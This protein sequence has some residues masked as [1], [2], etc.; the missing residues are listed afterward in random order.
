MAE[1][2]RGDDNGSQGKPQPGASWAAPPQSSSP[3][4]SPAGRSSPRGE[5][6]AMRRSL[7][8]IGFRKITLHLK[9]GQQKKERCA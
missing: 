4:A 2:K 8:H 1:R 3:S 5:Q 9:S 7:W 6:Q